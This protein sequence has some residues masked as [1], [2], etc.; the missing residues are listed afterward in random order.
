MELVEEEKGVVLASVAVLLCG[1]RGVGS[2]MLGLTIAIGASGRDCMQHLG[3]LL[4]T[5]KVTVLLA[6]TRYLSGTSLS[7]C[8]SALSEI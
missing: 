5:W 8:E 2:G 4:T 1:Q 3:T 7:V 6:F